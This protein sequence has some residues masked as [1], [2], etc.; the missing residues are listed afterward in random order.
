VTPTAVAESF[1]EVVPGFGEDW[2]SYA[3]P[4][5]SKGGTFSVGEVFMQ[6]CGFVR[7][8]FNSF[9]D[10]NVQELADFIDECVGGRY[11]WCVEDG[12]TTCFLESLAGEPF[13]ER[14]ARFLC[15]AARKYYD[16]CA[17]V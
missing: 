7:E 15:P 5:L 1:A 4:I 12:A 17:G 9:S 8:H 16:D 3:I 13:H 6:C 10:D 2:E 14:F 11:G